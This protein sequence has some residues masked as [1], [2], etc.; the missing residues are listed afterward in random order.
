MEVTGASTSVTVS[1]SILTSNYYGVGV[2]GG[3]LDMDHTVA[4]ANFTGVQVGAGTATLLHDTISFNTGDGVVMASNGYSLSLYDSIVS[5]NNGFGVYRPSYTPGSASLASNNVWSNGS[6]NYSGVSSSFGSISSDPLFASPTDFHLQASSPCRGRGTGGTDLGAL[7]Y[8]DD[9]VASVVI[10]PASTTVGATQTTAFTARAY[11]GLGNPISGVNFTWS[12][13]EAAGTIDTTGVLT[14]SCTT[15]TV[16]A[17][18]TATSP[19]GVSATAD[20]TLVPG[21]ATK[22]VISPPATGI[23]AGASRL[24]TASVLDSCGNARTTD[25]V[26]WSTATGAGTISATGQYTATCTP[27]SYPGAVTARLGALSNTA[28]VFVSTGPFTRLHVSPS[29]PSLA[30]GA[31]QAFSVM[32]TD[33]CG[34]VLTSPDIA[35][36]VVNGGG[37]IT[38]E[39]VFTSGTRAGFY[40]DTL[41]ASSGGKLGHTSVT[42]LGGEIVSLEL[43]PSTPTVEPKGRVTFKAVARDA[44]NNEVPATPTWSVIA[45]GGTIDSAGTFTAGTVTGTYTGTVRAVAGSASATATVV[46]KPG[47][48]ARIELSPSPAMLSP[49]GSVRFTARVLDAYDNLRTTD[50]VTWSLL[51]DTAGKFNTTPGDFTATTVAGNYTDAIRAEA[52]GKTA[53][54]SVLVRPGAL[55]R[56]QLSPSSASPRVGES[57]AFTAKGLDE[58]GNEVAITPFWEVVGGGGGISTIGTFTAGNL[59]GTYTDTVRVRADGLSA[60]A[61]VVVRPGPVVKV[62]LSPSSPSLLT[63]GTL[64]F[65]ARATDAFGNE[66]ASS[67]R[68]WSVQPSAGTLTAT[69]L[70]TAGNTAGFF[71]DAVA[72]EVEGV[73]AAT[74]VDISRRVARVEVSRT[75]TGALDAGGTATFTARAFD[76]SGAEVLD[77][78]LTWSARTGAGSIDSSGRLTVACTPG[79]F[80][81][82]VTATAEGISSSVDVTIVAG[83]AGRLT[84]SPASVLVEAKGSTSF[85]A[86]ATDTCGNTL[87][88][89]SVTWSTTSGAGSITE[90]GQYTAP[91]TVGSLPGAVVARL[92][93]LLASASVTVKPGAPA[94]LS[95]EPTSAML[96]VTETKQFSVRGA[97]VCGNAL[98]PSVSWEVVSGG[99]SVDGTGLLTA[100]TRAGS[101]TDTLRVSTGTLSASASLTVLPGALASMAISPE[102]TELLPAGKKTF[103]ARGADRF[104]NTVPVSPTWSVVAGGGSI[105]PSGEFTAG[106][107]AGTYTG[108]VRAESSDVSGNATVIVLAG[109]TTRIEL[110]PTSVVLEPGQERRFTA[111]AFDVFGNPS[112]TPLTWSVAAPEVGT[113]D[114]TGRFTAGTVAGS[115]AEAVRVSSGG[116]TVVANVTVVAGPTARV[117][118]TPLAPTVLVGGTVRFSARALDAHGNERS[119][120]A[121]WTSN[122]SAGAITGEG[123][124]TAGTRAGE[125]PDAVTA[126]FDG[127]SASTSVKVLAPDSPDSGT[128]GNDGGTGETPPPPPSGCGC[129]SAADASVPVALLLLALFMSRRRTF[130]V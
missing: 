23:E 88:P 21:P 58:Y 57:V 114:G 79:T 39:G 89:P 25:T 28:N 117:E 84:V 8:R 130:Q 92:G 78:G 115:Y 1:S 120:Q 14:A 105:L 128:G 91:C 42:V 60:T 73:K 95:V 67:P 50:T 59:A 10:E 80:S 2:S 104:G 98:T 118:L 125:F 127:V 63:R 101:Y 61:T 36:S 33:R 83:P 49:G 7:P 102:R 126:T 20:V 97:D 19:N 56:L 43:V 85:S 75:G 116:V 15:G 4:Y 45:G 52:G 74:S 81:A 11:S 41:Q 35:W 64:Q 16:T 65:T 70:F 37:S 122:A 38:S 129:S 124:F 106:T 87:P 40:A 72:V 47:P 46:I 34:N 13:K 51:T 22:V 30:L 27:G 107:A 96:A 93:G 32:A 119:A 53:Y 3:T 5:S 62:S 108:T 18:V 99:G 54:A 6:G 123:L 90:G 82:G 76:S 86:S 103:T 110:T 48:V 111:R 29:S 69:G 77:A 26:T 112:A 71:T 31:Q 12:A 24:F 100:G 109:S 44:Y 55:S 94:S 68:T 113:M 121:R 9:T 17:A 66:L